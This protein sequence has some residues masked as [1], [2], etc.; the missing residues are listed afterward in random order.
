MSAVWKVRQTADA[1]K[2]RANII[3]W[4]VRRQAETYTETIALALAAL[5]DGPDILG[6]KKRND[7]PHDIRILHV[8]REGRKGRHFI[9]FRTSGEADGEKVIEVL[10]L[11]HDSMDLS[12]HLPS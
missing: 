9:V 7:L 4:T 3:R 8:A 12:S 6:V 10:R 1:K 5:E 2:D 11:L